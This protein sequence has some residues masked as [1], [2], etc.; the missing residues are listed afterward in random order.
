MHA[1]KLSSLGN[2][3][4][5]FDEKEIGGAWQSD[6]VFDMKLDAGVHFLYY[7]PKLR[8]AI[9]YLNSN[10]DLD[11][12]IMKISPLGD[13][14]VFFRYPEWSFSTE[15]Y[16]LYQ[17]IRLYLRINTLKRL[18]GGNRYYYFQGGCHGLITRLKRRLKENRI[19]CKEHE[20]VLKISIRV[21]SSEKLQIK[22]KWGKYTFDNVLISSR[23]IPKEIEINKRIKKINEETNSKLAHVFIS[24]KHAGQPKFSVYKF[25]DGQVFAASDA[26]HYKDQNYFGESGETVFS[27][28]LQH[29]ISPNNVNPNDLIK[30]LVQRRVCSDSVEIISSTTRLDDV[31]NIDSRIIEDYNRELDGKAFILR[32]NNMSR[33]LSDFHSKNKAII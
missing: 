25:I 26:R 15:P 24:V 23:A 2:S 10:F 19:L 18:I 4:T 6:I 13:E 11:L 5:V 14:R 9:K 32:Y 33:A 31:L 1:I 12:R 22:T 7:H 28:A 20:K 8:Q 3:V 29:N 21:N 16:D 17:K 30:M 27:F